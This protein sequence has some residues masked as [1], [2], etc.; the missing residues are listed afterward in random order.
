MLA[1]NEAM[2]A[3]LRLA[4]RARYIRQEDVS[5]DHR[6]VDERVD[7]LCQVVEDLAALVM[8]IADGDK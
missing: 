1:H 5:A 6:D 7:R 2:K 4:E 3:A 8:R